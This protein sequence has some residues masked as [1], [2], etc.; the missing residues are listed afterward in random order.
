MS[1]ERSIPQANTQIEDSRFYPLLIDPRFNLLSITG[2]RAARARTFAAHLKE[3][4]N[5]NIHDLPRYITGLIFAGACFRHDGAV[6]QDPVYDNRYDEVGGSSLIAAHTLIQAGSIQEAIQLGMKF[7]LD[8]PEHYNW[9][10]DKPGTTVSIPSE[11]LKTILFRYAGTFPRS[12]IMPQLYVY[13]SRGHKQL[14]DY[15]SDQ[16]ALKQIS[17]PAVRGVLTAVLYSYQARFVM[18]A[19]ANALILEEGV[20]TTVPNYCYESEIEFYRKLLSRPADDRIPG[21][22]YLEGYARTLLAFAK[23][24]WEGIRPEQAWNQA[25]NLM[26]FLITMQNKQWTSNMTALDFTAEGQSPLRTLVRLIDTGLPDD[27]R[28]GTIGVTEFILK[29]PGTASILQKKIMG[30]TK[31]DIEAAQGIDRK[32]RR[33][34]AEDIVARRNPQIDN[35]DYDLI[36]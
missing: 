16:W 19:R 30:I 26:Y 18:K 11:D 14:S 36:D 32:Q 29:Y 24:E 20:T 2:D 13:K 21:L 5:T 4:F 28:R 6:A 23:T 15:F 8:E 17:E 31:D 33:L 35:V 10:P 12:L 3:E 27:L 25:R 1:Q 9:D 34:L 7:N 22:F